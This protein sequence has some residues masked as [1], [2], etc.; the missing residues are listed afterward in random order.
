MMSQSK[1][2][3]FRSIS[4]TPWATL[5]HAVEKGYPAA[6]I[7]DASA[8]Q[9]ADAEH[10]CIFRFP[11]PTEDQGVKIAQFLEVL[12]TLG[13]IGDWNIILDEPGRAYFD[14]LVNREDYSQSVNEYL[15]SRKEHT[16]D[17]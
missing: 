3:S 4:H 5:H 10:Q 1:R 11:Y 9:E 7:E 8:G 13:L 2:I 14:E 15:R 17:S 16:H 6:F 12:R